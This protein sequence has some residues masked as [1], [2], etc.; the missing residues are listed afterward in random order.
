MKILGNFKKIQLLVKWNNYNNYTTITILQLDWVLVPNLYSASWH[1]SDLGIFELTRPKYEFEEWMSLEI[2][3][4]IE[5]IN[6][7][8]FRPS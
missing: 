1:I 2:L 3:K 7:I 6:S 4:Y 5:N 8:G